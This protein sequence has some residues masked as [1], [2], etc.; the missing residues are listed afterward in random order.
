MD[1]DAGSREYVQCRGPVAKESAHYPQL[2]AREF[3]KV[4]QSSKSVTFSSVVETV[5]SSGAPAMVGKP[6]RADDFVYG[7]DGHTT[8]D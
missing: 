6:S 5:S 3:W 4:R 8:H 1:V 2:M 7:G